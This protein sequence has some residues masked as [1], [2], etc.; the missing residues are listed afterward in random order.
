MCEQCILNRR[1]GTSDQSRSPR[2][3]RFFDISFN[4]YLEHVDHDIDEL[5]HAAA[6]AAAQPQININTRV[7]DLIDSFHNQFELYQNNVRRSIYNLNDIMNDYAYNYADYQ[8]YIINIIQHTLQMNVPPL[9]S[10]GEIPSY[11]P[12]QSSSYTSVLL[13]LVT[14]SL[15]TSLNR[16]FL[17]DVTVSVPYTETVEIPNTR[18]PDTITSNTRTPNTRTPNTN[19]LYNTIMNMLIT[20][21]RD[22][23]HHRSSNGEHL[24]NE[25]ICIATRIIKYSPHFNE[26]RCPISLD[27]FVVDENICQIKQCSHIFKNNS[28]INWLRTNRHCPVC[29]YDLSTYVEPTAHETTGQEPTAHEPNV[30]ANEPEPEIIYD[31]VVEEE[32]AWLRDEYK[33]EPHNNTS[34]SSRIVDNIYNLV[35]S[36]LN[37]LPVNQRTITQVNELLQEYNIPTILQST[38]N[39]TNQIREHSN[40]TAIPTSVDNEQYPEQPDVD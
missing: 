30:Q 34:A 29:R 1:N 12:P 8:Y 18:T 37:A 5:P 24:T 17:P 22:R 38:L 40:N 25:Q 10:S 23:I 28:L 16:E 35:S 14:R 20:Q 27:E 36:G 19:S 32:P 39:I 31:I 33:S 11:T 13:D 3:P 6:Q 7:F 21:A 15:Q 26:Q 2:L 4:V 9:S